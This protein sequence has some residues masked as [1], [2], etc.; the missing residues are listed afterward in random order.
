[1][2]ELVSVRDLVK[3]YRIG[4]IEYPAL[5][6][7]TMSV[8][9]GEFVSVVGPSGSGKSTL[10]YIIGGL[11]A[12]TSGTV[13][14]DGVDISKLSGNELADYRNKK[15]G[16]VFQFFNLVQYLKAIENVELPLV[17]A[18]VTAG[19]RRQKAQELLAL[20]GLGDKTLKRPSELSGG[21]QQRVAIARSLIN[22]RSSSG[23]RANGQH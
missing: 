13:I 9:P 5:R 19:K 6:G 22:D 16:F 2:S 21:E 3:I 4:Q 10:L 20:F 11:D 14:V 18:G 8:S 15:M 7:V 17:V 1:M 23:R 12:A